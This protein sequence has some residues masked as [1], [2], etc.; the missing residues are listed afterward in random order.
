MNVHKHSQDN[1]IEGMYVLEVIVCR[2]EAKKREAHY[3]GLGYAGKK[4]FEK[5]WLDKQKLAS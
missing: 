3:H 1:N 2:E 5:E 4:G